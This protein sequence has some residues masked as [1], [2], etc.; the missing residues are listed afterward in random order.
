MLDEVKL[1]LRVDGT[2][3]DELIQGMIDAAIEY[4]KSASGKTRLKNGGELMESE[5]VKLAVKQLVTHWYD[6]RGTQYLSGH[7][8]NV[9][10]ISY[11]TTL[12]L[13]HITTSQEFVSND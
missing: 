3:E 1:Y 2:M 5:L 6:H 7:F 11:S 12:I 13:A 9:A 4:I 8:K 10:D